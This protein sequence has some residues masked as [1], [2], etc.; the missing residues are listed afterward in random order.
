MFYSYEQP[1]CGDKTCVS[2]PTANARS[3]P[4]TVEEHVKAD[5]P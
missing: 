2:G 4:K 3:C 1:R 5:W